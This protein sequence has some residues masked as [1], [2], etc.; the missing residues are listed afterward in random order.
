MNNQNQVISQWF[1]HKKEMIKITNDV[2]EDSDVKKIPENKRRLFFKNNSSNA[3][4]FDT[5]KDMNADMVPCIEYGS[6]LWHVKDVSGLQVEQSPYQ[7][8]VGALVARYPRWHLIIPD[9]IRVEKVTR[10]SPYSTQSKCIECRKY[11]N[12]EYNLINKEDAIFDYFYP[13]ARLHALEGIGKKS[14]VNKDGTLFVIYISGKER[15]DYNWDGLKSLGESRLYLCATK[16]IRIIKCLQTFP[17]SFDEKF[18]DIY[19][20]DDGDEILLSSDEGVMKF[21]PKETMQTKIWPKKMMNTFANI[22]FE[23]GN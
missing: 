9:C 6:K 23:F 1:F 5:Y 20:N 17:L 16:P 2:L 21:S 12:E 10:L 14:C 19:M 22:M 15:K 7:F 11:K 8:C 4:Y 3:V 18:R 13:S